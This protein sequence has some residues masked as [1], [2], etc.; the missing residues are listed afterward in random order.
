MIDDCGPTMKGLVMDKE[1]AAIVSMV[2]AQSEILQKEVFLF[3]RID[4]PGQKSLKHL[5]CICFVRPTE[6]NI[7]ALARELRDPKYGSYFI[8]FTNFIEMSDVK[9]LAEADEFECVRVIKEYYGDY[10]AVNPHL[11]SLNTPICCKTNYEWN[12]IVLRRCIQGLVSLLLSLRKKSASI[13]Y[14]KSSNMAKILADKLTNTL[15]RQAEFNISSNTNDA[16]Q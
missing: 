15:Q 2:Y 12:D 8:Y 3:E 7:Q 5:S 11:F 6:E 16:T 4:I 14:Q 13:R 1:T 9:A 10:L